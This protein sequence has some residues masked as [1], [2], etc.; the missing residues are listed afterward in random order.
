MKYAKLI[1]DGNIY[2]INPH[3]SAGRKYLTEFYLET[4]NNFLHNI[5]TVRKLFKP[6]NDETRGN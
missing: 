1:K 5:E 6:K 2:K 4:N 3:I